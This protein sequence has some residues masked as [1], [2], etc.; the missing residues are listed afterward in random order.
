MS[1]SLQFLVKSFIKYRINV[2]LN[3]GIAAT[4]DFGRN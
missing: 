3:Q 1:G 2:G 4:D